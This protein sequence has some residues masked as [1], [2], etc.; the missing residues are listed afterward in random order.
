[1]KVLRT[2]V[3]GGLLVGMAGGLSP[4]PD[5]A[6][7]LASTLGYL[8]VEA[9]NGPGDASLQLRDT[10]E[11]RPIARVQIDDGRVKQVLLAQLGGKPCVA[12]LLDGPAE[13]VR[14]YRMDRHGLHEIW[15]GIRSSLNPWKIAIVDVDGDGKEE[16]AVG[17]Y[18]KARYHPV[19]AKRLFIYGWDGRDVFA[20]WLGSRLSRPFTDFAFADF[21]SGNKL[22]AIEQT[23][24]AGNE[25]AVYA[26]DDFGF[27]GQWRGADARRLTELCV[28]GDPGRQ[29]ISVRAD[30][31]RRSY[32]LSSNGIG[33]KEDQL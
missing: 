13:A 16:I 7:P 12:A 6:R 29:R 10:K 4:R 3:I 22:I 30:G 17:V 23:R 5:P 1:M 14:L 8:R 18:K 2:A 15:C 20:K 24:D 9:R 11:D 26:W 27:T 28:H 32:A 25:L 19:M 31:I 33:L 21:G